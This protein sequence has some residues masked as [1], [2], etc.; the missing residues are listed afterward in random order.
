MYS[1]EQNEIAA[2]LSSSQRRLDCGNSRCGFARIRCPDCGSEFLLHFSCRTRGFCPSCHGK[3][4]EEWEEWMREKL[5]LDVPHRQVVFVIPRRLRIFFKY[6][7]QLL[8]Q[9]C[10]SAVQALI[11]YF[12]AVSGT[13]LVPGIVAVIQTFRQKINFHPHVHLLVTEGGE[14]CDGRF[15]HIPACSIRP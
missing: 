11:K 14:D 2:S 4:L 12:Q 9:L 5:L 3:R 8:G 10:H 1:V 13:E 6:K 7:R 15:H